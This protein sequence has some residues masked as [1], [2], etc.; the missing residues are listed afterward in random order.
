MAYT[1]E[2]TTSY[3]SLCNMDI[4]AKYKKLDHREH[5]LARPGMYIGSIEEDLCNTW[6][7]DSDQKTMVKKDVRIVPGL[8]KI[9][10]EILVNAVD[11]CTRLKMD[12]QSGKEVQSVKNIKVV[13]D[14]EKG[15]VSVMNDGDGIDVE[16]HPEHK[17]YIPEL[18]F[19]YMLTST[20]YDDKEEKVV[21]GTNGL[22]SKCTNIFSKSFMV[23]TVDAA[24]K[25]IYHQEF[26]NNMSEKT[27]PVIKYCAKKPY[28]VIT[29]TPDYERFNMTKGLTQDMYDL[30]V[31]RCYDMC[32]MTDSDV[33]VFLN[34]EKLDIKTF[35]RYVDLY[36]GN[37]ADHPRVYEKLNDRWE[38]A[39]SYTDSLGFDQV[40]FVNGI[41]TL[42]GGK[43][44]DYIVNQITS[45][46]IEMIQKKK[47]D[48][49]VKPAHI[50]NHLIVF[51]KSTIVNPTFDS[52]TKDALTTTVA[53]FGSKAEIDEKFIDKLYKTELLDRALAMCD[54]T[55]Q[56]NIK[57]TDGKK[58]NRIRGLVKLDDANWSG[59]NKSKEC[60]LIL[61]E[62][63]SAKST[64]LTGL[65]VVGRD[66][67]G[68][69][70]LRGKLMNVKDVTPKKLLENE[71]IQNIKKIL[72]LESGKVYHNL[73][74]LRYGRIMIMSDQDHD[75]SHIRGLIMNLFHTLW[76]SLLKTPSF[77]TSLLTPIVKVTHRRGEKLSFYNMVEYNRWLAEND[78]GRGWHI[79]Y[80]KGLG[81]SNEE[82]AR[83]YFKHM[84]LIHYD[85][86]GEDSHSS[87]DLAFNKKRADDRKKWLSEYEPE[88]SIVL[89]Q[90]EEHVSYQE[91][92]NRELIHFSV[93]DVKRSIPCVV[94]GLK[95]SQRKILYTCFKRN[96]VDEIKVAQ[97]AGSVSEQAAYHHGEA[98]L[99]GAIICM[100][101]DFVGANNIQLLYPSGMFGTRR[102]GGKDASA[103]RYIFTR[104]ESITQKIFRKEDAGLLNYLED[105]GFKVE[106]AYY[107]PIIPMVLI[108]GACGIGT[109]FSTSIPSYNPL[110]II[111]VMKDCIETHGNMEGLPK[112]VP[113]YRGFHGT[114]EEVDGKSGTYVSRGCYNMLDDKTLEITEL[115]IGLWTEDYKAFLEE[116]LEKNP[117]ILKD[118][119]SHYTNNTVRFKLSF[120]PKELE[121]FT[122][123]IDGIEKE[124]KLIS[125]NISTTNMHL[126]DARGV[127][128]KYN[129]IL[130]I[131]KDFY[132]I[133]LE[134]YEERKRRI[135]ADLEE[136]MRVL[137]AKCA[138][139]TEVMAGTINI[140]NVSKAKVEDQLRTKSYHQVDGG[141][142]YLLR[143]PIYSFTEEKYAE[144][145]GEIAKIKDLLEKYRNKKA[146]AIWCDELDE[147]SKEYESY[148]QEYLDKQE[149]DATGKKAGNSDMAKRNQERLLARRSRY[150]S[151]VKTLKL[152]L[153]GFGGGFGFRGFRFLCFWFGSRFLGFLCEFL[154]Q[155][156]RIGEGNELTFVSDHGL[157]ANFCDFAL[158]AKH[159]DFV[160][161]TSARAARSIRT[162]T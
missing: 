102:L 38:V 82:E 1:R 49:D 12:K 156:A 37:K 43:H 64:A 148:Y 92:I 48:V 78:G 17:I 125:R 75:G 129:D 31:K 159:S 152:Y 61:T 16:E 158:A 58:Q 35:E 90:N 45:K 57:K 36:L 22:G 86:T 113:W 139:I 9:F 157:A 103:P 108:N 131:V 135:V 84:H 8:Y 77:V 62:G 18:I 134:Y 162:R 111:E 71:E 15:S 56:Q 32:A 109:G 120:Q 21:G 143:M 112:L 51:V 99:Q 137:E 153:L 2:S 117:K 68:V 67:Y 155:G 138:M 132:E 83:D 128:K 30:F 115:P 42:K 4:Q 59:T 65:S 142:E 107:M 24:R 140:M 3:I 122:N 25:R 47:K 154:F 44:V 93:Y 5:V 60:I 91:F 29:F 104:L 124:F 70:P 11:H 119:E 97:L 27:V 149:A 23:E 55:T 101:Q 76:P 105:D 123:E 20:N 19:G 74:D 130:E 34:G 126:F 85:Y 73:D 100:A 87:M 161:G 66:R 127:I 41:W 116:Y 10:D 133:R 151:E 79:K 121:K 110:D 147:L 144:L 69:F 88:S 118:Y 52:Q 14:R 7:Y 46:L 13:I 72:G 40:S 145:K 28:T 81:T 6:V 95:P 114:I 106:P 94:D 50:K 160:F 54:K 80:Y 39:A 98:S 63:D 150:R 141:Y 53:K 33:N 26:T 146:T 136:E 89:E 96:L